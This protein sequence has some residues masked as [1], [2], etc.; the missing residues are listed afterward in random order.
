MRWYILGNHKCTTSYYL[1]KC[2]K[3]ISI[4]SVEIITKK[5]KNDNDDNKTPLNNTTENISLHNIV[6]RSD[7]T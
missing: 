6:P 7:Y 5:K 2:L 4:T 3:Y 1:K